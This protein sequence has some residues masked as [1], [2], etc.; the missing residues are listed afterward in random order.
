[1]NDDDGLLVTLVEDMFKELNCSA[2]IDY[3]FKKKMGFTVYVGTTCEIVFYPQKY[4]QI[5][6]SLD[7]EEQVLTLGNDEWN[8]HHVNIAD[9]ELLNKLRLG[10]QQLTGS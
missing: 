2:H 1:M 3:V 10:I 9:P 8:M 4:D 6:L 7:V 5:R